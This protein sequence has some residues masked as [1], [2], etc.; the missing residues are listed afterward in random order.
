[1]KTPDPLAVLP[2][3]LFHSVPD[4]C[5][6]G[7]DLKFLLFLPSLCLYIAI[8]HYVKIGGIQST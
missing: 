2:G 7:L 5:H 4:S 8:L 3:A 6:K 1:M